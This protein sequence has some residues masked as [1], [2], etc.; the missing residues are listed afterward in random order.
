MYHREDR[1][2]HYEG[3]SA[4]VL[5]TI[6]P[7]VGLCRPH[8]LVRNL[9][10]CKNMCAKMFADTKP[11]Q[12]PHSL[13]PGRSSMQFLI[14]HR[15]LKEF[16]ILYSTWKYI[17]VRL[18]LILLLFTT[19]QNLLWSFE[20]FFID[21]TFDLPNMHDDW[22]LMCS[23]AIVTCPDYRHIWTFWSHGPDFQW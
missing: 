1:H 17:C 9:F 4:Y 23:A 11:T 16:L 22:R 21:S 20:W 14:C 3:W 12:H 5:C 18:F 2:L 19:R 8:V 10:F 13:V 6:V 15:K 7:L